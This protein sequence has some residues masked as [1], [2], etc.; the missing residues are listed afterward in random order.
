MA[1]ATSV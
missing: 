1:N